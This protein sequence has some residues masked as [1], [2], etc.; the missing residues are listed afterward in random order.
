MQLPYV[1]ALPSPRWP[2][3][4]FP[5]RHARMIE[6]FSE[7]CGRDRVPAY[8][9]STPRYSSA[10]L[11]LRCA[12]QVGRQEKSCRISNGNVPV[13]F[14]R[15]SSLFVDIPQPARR[16]PRGQHL[17]RP[18]SDAT[19]DAAT[20]RT[21]SH[22]LFATAANRHRNCD[23]NHIPGLHFA[24]AWSSM[25]NSLCNKEPFLSHDHN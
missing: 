24:A 19:S 6:T 2:M 8:V 20:N 23:S 18:V 10:I 15:R 13:S 14:F 3:S 16:G 11:L 17:R 1:A 7:P 12:P 21:S 4:P 9:C 25:K 22:F 5:C